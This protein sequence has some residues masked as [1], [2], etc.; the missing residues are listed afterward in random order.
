MSTDF[1]S[2]PIPVTI[3]A[4][5][6]FLDAALREEGKALAAACAGPIGSTERLAAL[7]RSQ[8]AHTLST[9]AICALRV[10]IE[11]AERIDAAAGDA[12]GER[13]A[14]AST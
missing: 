1:T 10:L 4:A 11:N 9:T 14:G 6:T 2:G 13:P 5:R 7:R 12:P 3:A 8:A